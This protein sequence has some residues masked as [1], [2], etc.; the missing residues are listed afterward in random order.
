MDSGDTAWVIVSSAFVLFMAQPGLAIF[1]GGLVRAKNVLSILMQCFAICCIV[2][3]LWIIFGY[4][5]AYSEGNAFIG[6]F[7]YIFLNHMSVLTVSEKA[8]IPESVYVLY[9]MMFAVI[10][11]ALMVGAFAERIKFSAMITFSVLWF[12][13][14][15]LPICHMAWAKGGLFEQWNVIDFAGGTV[16]HV[17]AGVAALVGCIMI[18]KRKGAFQKAIKPHSLPIT[19]VGASMLWVGWFGFNGGSS[20]AADGTA[21]MAL[22]VTHLSAAVSATT[23]MLLEWVRQG[24][25]SVLGIV[26]GTVSGLVAITP[27]ASV[28]GPLGAILIGATASVCSYF[29]ATKV[30]NMLKFDDSLDVFGVHGVGGIV[31]AL[32]TGVVTSPFFG[33]EGFLAAGG[34][35]SQLWAQ[36]L[37]VSVTI[38]WSG[39]VSF[40]LFKIIDMTMGFRVD[41]EDE[42]RGLDLSDHGEQG[43]DFH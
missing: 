20:L 41:G 29:V 7:D 21:G 10:T 42:M 19:V 32:L 12:I 3:I 4:S 8:D 17:N 24:K 15:Y 6:G 9:Q 34:I 5:L 14:S 16:V 11:P 18:G 43:Y 25:A 1:Y 37:G 2:S 31:G 35:G 30:K 27:A 23:W 28:S 13:L 26:T 22:L 40:T 39:V 38:V 36:L 33:G